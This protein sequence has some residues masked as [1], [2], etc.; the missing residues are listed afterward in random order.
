MDMF[1]QPSVYIFYGLEFQ[2]KSSLANNDHQNNLLWPVSNKLAI[3]K[4]LQE[5]QSDGHLLLRLDQTG[6]LVKWNVHG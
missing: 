4:G 1:K 6:R 5:I 3:F 2:L